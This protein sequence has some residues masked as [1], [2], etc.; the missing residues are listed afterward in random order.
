MNTLVGKL[1]AGAGA[2]VLLNGLAVAQS[3][4]EVQVQAKRVMSTKTVQRIANGVPVT[5]ITVSY[6]VSAK[7]I[8]LATSSGAKLLEQR[9]TDAAAA[10]CK[11]ITRQFPEAT[12]SETECAASAAGKAMSK[13]RELVAAAEKS[14][15]TPK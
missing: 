12:P 6:G 14:R 3:V 9:V 7:D 10:A 5:D 1:A 13:V 2:A 15:A 4:S 11:E 8:D